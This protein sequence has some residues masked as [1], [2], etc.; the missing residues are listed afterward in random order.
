[1]RCERNKRYHSK[2]LKVLI[3]TANFY[4]KNIPNFSDSWKNVD[5]QLSAPGY[6]KSLLI[7]YSKSAKVTSKQ[8]LALC[9]EAANRGVQWKKMFSKISQNLENTFF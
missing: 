8:C 4:E 5:I 1:M 3:F 7:I 9:S 2:T 6:V